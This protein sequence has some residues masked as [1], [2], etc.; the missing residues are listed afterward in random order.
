MPKFTVEHSI[1]KDPEETY[2]TVKGF[3]S[4]SGEIKKLDA[5]AK[6]LFDDSKKSAAIS[7]SQFKAEMQ[8]SGKGE[9]SKVV[10]TVD[11]PFLLTPFK[12]KIQESLQ[13]MLT[14]HLV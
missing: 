14:K 4:K 13:K 6:C 11:L 9:S 2:K 7:G 5:N 10:I 8:V 12:G 1:E 3:L